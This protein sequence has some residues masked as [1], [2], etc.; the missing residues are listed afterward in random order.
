MKKEL[1]LGNLS[2]EKG[3]K[4]Q[5][6]VN[7]YETGFYFPVTLI[8]GIQNGKTILLTGGIH[9]AEYPGIQTTIELASEL[10]PEEVSGQLIII[11]PVNTEAFRKKISELVPGDDKNL[12][13]VFPGDKEGTLAEQIAH[14]ITH[15]CQSQADFYIDL[16]GGDLHEQS[17]NFVY[18]PGIAAE[19]VIAASRKVA[20][21]LE[22][23]YMVKSGATTGAY[24]S[25]AKRG[26]PSI[27]IER[28]GRGSWTKEEVASYK[29]DIKA[30]L[31][32]LDILNDE[33]LVIH[34]ENETIDII[35]AIYLE[36]ELEGCWYPEV[37]AGEKVE[38]GQ[39]L[40]SIKD[41]F[42]N[43]LQTYYAEVSGIV[44]YMTI[45]LA[46]GVGN[47]LIAYGKC[48]K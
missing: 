30:V 5:G 39:L 35:K 38:E 4:V 8:N 48:N 41:F 11:H 9:G 43:T 32:E 19:E 29:R 37:S 7:V 13:R 22:T 21:V 28:G 40:G 14:F 15:E 2:A 33:A 25:A 24:N 17:T 3:E 27:L 23:S 44:L 18:Y 16:H 42:G 26:L 36:S 12:N 6:M 34:K 46:V 1:V 47:P 20:A 45:A 31:Y 10:K